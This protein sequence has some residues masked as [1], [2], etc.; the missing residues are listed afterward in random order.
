MAHFEEVD[1][2]HKVSLPVQDD[3]NATGKLVLLRVCDKNR[4]DRLRLNVLMS[5]TS[6]AFQVFSCGM[7]FWAQICRKNRQTDQRAQYIFDKLGQFKHGTLDSYGIYIND[8][9]S[10][11]Y[12]LMFNFIG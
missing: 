6:R 10:I 2:V 12:E 3:L 9:Y 11:L 4:Q 1:L 5:L 7:R 8:C